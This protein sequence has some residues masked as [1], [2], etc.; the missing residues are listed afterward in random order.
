MGI[1]NDENKK[2]MAVQMSRM[3]K[4]MSHRHLQRRI[5]TKMTMISQKQRSHQRR[6][7]MIVDGDDDDDDSNRKPK[8]PKQRRQRNEPK[9]PTK[10]YKIFFSVNIQTKENDNIGDT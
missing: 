2:R 5:S 10:D 8:K 9:A 7:S 6:R 1:E 3:M 4:K